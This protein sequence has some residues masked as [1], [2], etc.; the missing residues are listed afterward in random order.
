VIAKPQFGELPLQSATV[1]S[2]N[3]SLGL[4]HLKRVGHEKRDAISIRFAD[5]QS[6]PGV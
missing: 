3:G 1:A 2:K 4:S 6:T 5:W